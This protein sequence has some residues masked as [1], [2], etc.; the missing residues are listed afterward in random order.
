LSKVST[1]PVITTP[2]GNDVL[3]IITGMGVDPTSHRISINDFQK[4]IHSNTRVTATFTV[5]GAFSVTGNTYTVTTSTVSFRNFT[6]NN[7]VV[8]SNG[9]IIRTKYTPA[10][11]SISEAGTQG[12]ISYDS[13]YLYVKTAN[14]VTK[15]IALSSF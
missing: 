3:M 9:V 12:K 4:N 13:N 10:N 6:A 1:Y 11:S 15:R 2:S 8:A 5:N 14:N 7:V